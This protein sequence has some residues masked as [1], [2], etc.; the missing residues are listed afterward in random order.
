MVALAYNPST[1]EAVAGGSQ[2]LGHS[3]S[4]KPK[5]KQKQKIMIALKVYIYWVSLI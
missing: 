1:Q 4:K 2:V 5:Q 3:V